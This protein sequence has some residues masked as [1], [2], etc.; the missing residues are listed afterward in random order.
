MIGPKYSQL[1][2]LMVLTRTE[3]VPV[4]RSNGRDIGDLEQS[5]L[6]I[7]DDLLIFQKNENGFS[8]S[9]PFSDLFSTIN[10][11]THADG[12]LSVAGG[13]T[14]QTG[15]GSTPVLFT[16]FDTDG[17]S[18]NTAPDHTIDGITVGQAGGY[19]VQLQISFSGS[20]STTFTFEIYKLSVSP[21]SALAQ[22]IRFTRKLG[23]GGDVGS[24]SCQGLVHLLE[25]DVI[26]V[27]VNADTEGNSI[28]PV[29]A[30]LTAQRVS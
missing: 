4:K 12:M 29:D 30:Q 20:N 26:G 24:G 11:R 1:L 2:P 9:I 13:S 19:S 14:A 8:Y 5:S 15:I 7:D 6:I 21:P 17:P 23:T 22:P 16:G 28:T 27:F 3:N 25:N 10:N 18:E